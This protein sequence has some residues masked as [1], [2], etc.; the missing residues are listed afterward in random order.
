ML[1]SFLKKYANHLWIILIFALISFWYCLP[2]FQGKKIN[3]HDTISWEA[4]IRQLQQYEDSTGI[5]P[6]WSNAM[7]GGM[8]TYSIYATGVHNY[9]YNIQ[10]ALDKIVPFPAFLFFYCMLGF[11][12]LGLALGFQKWIAALGAVAY[13]FATYNLG[14]VASGHITKMYSLAEMPGVLAGLILI[15]KGNRWTGAALLAVFMSLL[16]SAGHYQMVYYTMIMLFFAALWMSIDLFR[17]KEIKSWLIST[18]VIVGVSLLSF[19]PSLPVILSTKEYTAYTMRG[20]GSELNKLKKS[21][22]KT[23]GGLD[24]EYAYRWSNDIGETFC[25]L[26]P[27]LY[28]GG[29]GQNLGTDSKFYEALTNVG[30]PEQ[31]AEQYASQAPTYWGSQ[32]FL[33]GPVYFGAI[34]CFLFVLGMLVVPSNH[35]WWILTTCIIAVLLSFGRNLPSLNNWLF[36][37][38]PYYNKFRVPSMIL[39][40]PQLLFPLLGMW[41]LNDILSKKISGAELI[42]KL[43]TATLI[44]AGICILVGVGGQAFFDFKSSGLNTSDQQLAEQFSKSAG[45]SAEIGQK[46]IKALQEDRAN[47]AMKSGLGSALLILAAAGLIWAFEKGKIKKEVAIAG[48]ALLVLLDLIPTAKKYLNDNNFIDESEYEA[49][50]EPRPVDAQILKDPDPYYR[51]LDLSRNTFND[52]VQSAIHKT[53][54]GY[55]AIKM[56]AYQDLIDIYLSGPFNHQVLNMLNTK[57]VIFNGGPNGQAVAQANPQ[58]CG[59]AWFVQNVKFVPDADAEM[60]SMRAPGFGDTLQMPNAWNARQTAIVRNTFAS[61]LNN[62]SSFMNDSTSSILLDKYGLNEISFVSQNAH[63]G[64]AV[65]SDVYYDKGWKAY[66]DGKESP[67]VRTDYILRGLSIPAGKH[68]IEFKFYPE[69]FYKSNNF[70]GISSILIYLLIGAALFMAY[71]N[72]KK[73]QA[74]S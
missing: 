60:E 44:T 6:L 9:I 13:A 63:N 2:Q 11:F 48:I 41:A 61:N 65:F 15:Y 18:L 64:F 23:K 17:K 19:G 5:K 71:K 1:N 27:Q 12:I 4:S 30:V 29:N 14:L 36:Y 20:G 46:V 38:L 25:F 52:A 26:I 53:V 69:T 43:K 55:S 50:F 74:T 59:N 37:N 72:S 7:F 3:M 16:L 22:T 62:Q 73:V 57:Y 68:K 49:Q 21:S 35:K 54:G 34:I 56:E 51:V 33:A 70:A 32:P 39:V 28:G 40:L 10:T 66:I 31:Y 8:P 67:I 24:I 42:K 58:A 47:M 45:G